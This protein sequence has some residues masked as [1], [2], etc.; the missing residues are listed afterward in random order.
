MLIKEN[1]KQKKNL[2][3]QIAKMYNFCQDCHREFLEKKK[4]GWRR[5]ITM[6]GVALEFSLP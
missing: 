6:G 3:F 1:F 4:F 2:K 5:I